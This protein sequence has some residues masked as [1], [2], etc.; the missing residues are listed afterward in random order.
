[1]SN[2][3]PNPDLDKI[4]QAEV[5]RVYQAAFD[6]VF[7]THAGKP[8]PEVE[9]ALKDR[10]AQA[11]ASLTDEDLANVAAQIAAGTKVEAI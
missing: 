3:V 11:R 6:D 9:A 10:L 1:M 5:K 7:E 4:L 2:F 8:Q